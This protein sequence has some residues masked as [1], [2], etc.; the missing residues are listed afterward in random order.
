LFTEERIRAAFEE[1]K[2]TIPPGF[3]V[4][5]TIY[6]RVTTK[7]SIIN[8]MSFV[9]EKGANTINKD[10]KFAFK[11]DSVFLLLNKKLPDFKLKDLK[12]N[13]FSSRQLIGKP[14]LINFWATYCVP[15]VA[16]MPELSRLKEKY[17]EKMNF[18]GLTEN[19][20][21]ADNLVSFLDKHPFNYQILQNAEEYKNTLKISAIPRNIF[22]DKNGYIR[23]IKGNFPV[24][25]S[26]S[27]KSVR[28]YDENN[29]FVK[30]ID[31]LIKD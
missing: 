5:P 28:E 11:Q 22:V 7:D 3:V 15:C 16:E 1:V 29:Q 17:V 23:Y 31:K 8:Y 13:E 21:K 26:D 24:T 19:K 9:I 14:T 25:K 18:L 20:S 10:F 2:K 12:G 6:H 30:I 27:T 4:V